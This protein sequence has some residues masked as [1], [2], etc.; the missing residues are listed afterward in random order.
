ML[1]NISFKIISRH[2]ILMIFIDFLTKQILIQNHVFIKHNKAIIQYQKH[3]NRK[4]LL[5]ND[6]APE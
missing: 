3:V 2:E 4:N 6:G 1:K 5:I